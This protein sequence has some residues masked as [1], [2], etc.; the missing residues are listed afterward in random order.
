M[1][2]DSSCPF[3][4][5]GCCLWWHERIH[6]KGPFNIQ[7]ENSACLAVAG[8]SGA[9]GERAA[10]RTHSLCLAHRPFQDSS[11]LVLNFEVGDVSEGG[12]E[13]KKI[14]ILRQGDEREE[15]EVILTDSKAHKDRTSLALPTSNISSSLGSAACQS[16][17]GEV[18]VRASN[19][20]GLF[21]I[22]NSAALATV[23][24]HF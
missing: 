12:R 2:C 17:H 24:V 18:N 15:S 7:S 11:S 13:E 8:T 4:F 6:D 21:S 1:A 16:L 3:S 19:V 10:A 14:C 22:V 9:A 23:T 5:F 20:I